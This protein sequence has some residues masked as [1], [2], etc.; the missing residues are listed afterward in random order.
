[1]KSVHPTSI[2]TH[3]PVPESTI[4][5]V[6]EVLFHQLSAIESERDQLQDDNK[7][8]HGQ[9]VHLLH[10]NNQLRRLL[11]EVSLASERT[12]EQVAEHVK[13]KRQ[14]ERDVQQRDDAVTQLRRHS[15]LLQ[16]QLARRYTWSCCV[17][18][19]VCVCRMCTCSIGFVALLTHCIHV[20]FCVQR[21]RCTCSRHPS[22]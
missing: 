21:R 19:C 15:E 17:C 7:E 3:N 22:T 13:V 9:L 20:P 2:Q 18:V 8:A 10:Q 5:C 1:V 4:P 16:Q 11:S 14:L 6:F 12:A